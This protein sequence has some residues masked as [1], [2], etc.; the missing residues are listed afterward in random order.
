MGLAKYKFKEMERPD[1]AVVRHLLGISGETD[2]AVL[3]HFH[4]DALTHSPKSPFF[5]GSSI[6]LYSRYS[7]K[8]IRTPNNKMTNISLV[9]SYSI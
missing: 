9:L 8:V 3:M 5:V 1:G 7:V 6:L 2:A 4:V